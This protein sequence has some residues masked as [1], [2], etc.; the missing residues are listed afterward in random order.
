MSED[1]QGTAPKK[2]F[3]KT[4]GCQMNVYD[5]ARMTDA[6]VASGYVET[7]AAED[8]DLIVLNTCHIREKAAEKVY[9]ELGRLRDLRR[10]RAARGKTTMI[11]VAGCVAQAEGEE[12]MRRAPAVDL[13]FGPQSY[14]RLPELVAGAARAPVIDTDFPEEDKFEHLPAPS[15]AATIARGV[16]AFLTVQ[17]GCD[18]FCSFC[19][20]PYTRGAEVSRPAAQVI[21]EAEQL[22]GAGVREITLL[23]QN[24]NA[25]HGADGAGGIMGLGALLRRLSEIEGL[26]R[27][28]YTTSH[29]R[30]MDDELIAAHGDLPQLMPYLHL[31]VQ[32]G[33]DRI[34][35]SMNRRHTAKEYLA[36]ITRIRH[37]RPDIALSGDFIVGFPGETDEDFE[38]TLSIVRDTG[39]AA[40]YSFKYSPRPGTPGAEL[41]DQVPEEVKSERLARLQLLI[42]SQQAAFNESCVGRT[43]PVLFEKPGRNK[44]QLVG[45]S[46]YLQ[47][48]AIDAS[49]DL[50]GRI[51]QVEITG[52]AKNSLFGRIVT[53][54]GRK[55]ANLVPTQPNNEKV[56]SARV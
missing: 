32:S 17:E 51:R 50:T 37:V 14:H 24:V 5:S 55:S 3:I 31:P 54:P 53:E 23:G 30:D 35:K 34:L 20:V 45:R 26:A 2:L 33:S 28:R 19:V 38:A 18:K 25:Y 56:R 13:V 7:G 10:T 21:A 36:L 6:L 22:A 43:V 47:S 46:P 12:I 40:A 49:E 52:T 29:P 48:V 44:G 16:T 9:S 27:L 11:G 41:E 39:Y 15:R 8:A 1:L 4:Y 42:A